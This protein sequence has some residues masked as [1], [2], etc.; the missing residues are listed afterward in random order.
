MHFI[1]QGGWIKKMRKAGFGK[2]LFWVSSLFGFS[3]R[4]LEAK[5]NKKGIDFVFPCIWL[6]TQNQTHMYATDTNY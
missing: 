6:N 2:L 1:W 3:W 4:G 5:L